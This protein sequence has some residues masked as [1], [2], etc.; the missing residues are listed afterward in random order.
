M[1]LNTEDRRNIVIY[2]LE[3]S[4]AAYED[5]ALFTVRRFCF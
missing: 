3:K 5:A 1:S 2:R 4:L